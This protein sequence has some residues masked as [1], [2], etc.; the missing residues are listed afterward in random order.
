MIDIAL[1]APGAYAY[2]TA[3]RPYQMLIPEPLVYNYNAAYDDWSREPKAGYVL[4]DNGAW[5][6][7]MLPTSALL[8]ILTVRQV[9]EL[10]VPDS[11]DDRD[12]T[13]ELLDEFLVDAAHSRDVRPAYLMAVAHGYPDEA[14]AFVDRVALH[15]PEVTCIGIGRAYTR[16]N[17]APKARPPLALWIKRNYPHLDVHL[18]G[19]NDQWPYEMGA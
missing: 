17:S 6:K 5:E 16:Y 19:F 13:L 12:A 2:T 4:M 18:L 9:D 15:R 11:L 7:P 1:I 8:N 3:N 14:K 10:I